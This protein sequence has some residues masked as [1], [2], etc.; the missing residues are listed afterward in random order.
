MK[1]ISRLFCPIGLSLLSGFMC[2]SQQTPAAGAR[3]STMRTDPS[4]ND[5]HGGLVDCEQDSATFAAP[6]KPNGGG[7]R[8]LIFHELN[9]YGPSVSFGNFGGWTVTHVIEAPSIVF[10]TSG[11]D[12]Y[13]SANIV[14]NGVGDLAGLYFYVY[15]GGRAA[16]SDE[17]VTG[18][19][20]ES[21]E[22]GGYFHGTITGGAAAGATSLT[23]AGAK[24]EHNWNATCN[25]C[26]LLDISKGRIAGRLN[27]KSQAFGSTF[28]FELPTTAVMIGGAPGT[29]PLTHAWCTTLNAV[30]FSDTAGTG[31]SRTVN[32]K[33]GA[34]GQSMGAFTAGGVVTVAGPHYPEQ[35]LITAVGQPSGGS[36]TLTLSIQNPHEAG[37]IIFQG[38]IAGQSLSFDDNLAT[39][40]FR[41]SYYVFGSVDGVNL[42]Y[43]SQIG[44]GIAGHTLPR[45]GFEAEGLQ[46][47]FHLYPS[48]EV[49][50]NTASPSAPQL[51][52][53]TVDWAAG[54]VVENPRFQSY[55]GIGVRDSCSAFT[56][57]DE[58]NSTGCMM[59]ELQ[60][61]G[62]SGTYHPFR[63]VNYN[64]PNLYKG[65]GGTV[66]AVPAMYYEGNFSETIVSQR[67][68]M[69]STY[70]YN[71]VIDITH[72][73]TGDKTPFNLFALPG[74][75]PGQAKVTYDP[76]TLLIGF[77]QGLVAS[78]MGTL[79]N[80]SSA[81]SP[82]NCG[83]AAAG[84]IAISS[85]SMNTTIVTS[86]VTA[87]SQILITPDMSL[88][89]KLGITCNKNAAVAFAPFGIAKRMPGSGFVL[90]VAT[91]VAGAPACFSYTIIN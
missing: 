4:C 89:A 79:S 49:V 67:G 76:A 84:S 86:A 61:P 17:G 59:L 81:V 3:T 70:G 31:T 26:M 54:D 80:C 55:G 50:A 8:T 39:T 63:I 14:K 2:F 9:T 47:G 43:G 91:S 77:P 12:Q 38:G 10:G 72:T 53:N 35:A 7:H 74:S 75:T 34:I 27:G 73:A 57:S 52:A 45:L 85:G 11:I 13:E 22:I 46:S 28:L 6:E 66:D 18:L 40:G 29:L 60:G 62:V 20:V 88:D 41:S 68:P 78:S 71:A 19:T 30:P 15:G 83:S 87:R 69:A 56:P 42:I 65:G 23:L 44:G 16:A 82:A 1:R 24:A 64:Y 5:S 25:G 48:A 32:C 36:Q 51:E 33:L 21:G 58:G 37:S 90:A